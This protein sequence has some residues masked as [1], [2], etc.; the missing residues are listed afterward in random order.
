MHYNCEC[1]DE[2]VWKGEHCELGQDLCQTMPCKN[3]GTCYSENG[4]GYNCV[5]NP[6]F[7]GETCETVLDHCTS[8]PCSNGSVCSVSGFEF[9]CQCAKGFSGLNCEKA[10]D[11]CSSAPCVFGQ[12]VEYSVEGKFVSG[13][14]LTVFSN[15]QNSFC[16][17]LIKNNF[18]SKII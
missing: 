17:Q 10:S 3:G 4:V 16:R 14:S 11:V 8:D 9:K 5:C 18:W 13:R 12:C 1:I 15:L 6:G 2:N 7:T